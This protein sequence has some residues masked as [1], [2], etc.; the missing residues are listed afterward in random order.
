MG[1]IVLVRHGQAN[2]HA[3]NEDDYD[4][5]SDLGHQQ[6]R[7]L[8]DWLRDRGERFDA[9]LSGSLRRHRETAAGMGIEATIDER[10]NEMDYFNLGRALENTHGVP[11]PDADGFPDHVPQVMRAWHAAEIQGNLSFATFEARI[12]SVLLD[13]SEEG[14]RTLC[15]T[16]GGVIG[17]ALRHVLDLDPT[18]LSQVLLPIRNT[19]IHR[20]HIRRGQMLMAGFNATPH[21]DRDDRAHALTHY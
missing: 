5:L 1:E 9:V 12:T 16:S 7:W 3:D 2:S 15:I 18:R 17:M 13:A 10:L 11:M 19:S 8:G 4:R 6:S 20:F 14:R 21:L